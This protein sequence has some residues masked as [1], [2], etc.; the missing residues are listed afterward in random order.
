M[1]ARVAERIARGIKARTDKIHQRRI[2][3]DAVRQPGGDLQILG[4]KSAGEPAADYMLLQHQVGM[5]VAAGGDVED[6]HHAPGIKAEALASKQCLGTGGK[7]RRGNK[8][9]QRLHR[10][11]AA[12]AS[13]V[14]QP[15]AH[16]TQQRTGA[17]D[18]TLV[19][20]GE[21]GA[22][23]LGGHDH[24]SGSGISVSWAPKMFVNLAGG[25]EVASPVGVEVA[26]TFSSVKIPL[27][28]LQTL[29]GGSFFGGSLSFVF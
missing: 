16:R 25:G 23:F 17:L 28:F 20:G 19:V 1:V 2:E 24:K 13:S 29:D 8:V 21:L 5:K 9:V 4:L 18:G 7:G 26:F 10:V 6:L 14:K 27:W 3:P 11:S 15:I 12:Q 22:Q